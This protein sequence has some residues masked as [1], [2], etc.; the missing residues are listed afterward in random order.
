[1]HTHT[2]TYTRVHVQDK[3]KYLSCTHKDHRSN[4]SN[5]G[6][7]SWFSSSFRKNIRI[8]SYYTPQSIP[9]KFIPTEIHRIISYSILRNIIC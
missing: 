8:A 5:P 2:H 7:F 1:M 9:S 6:K 3:E 4:L